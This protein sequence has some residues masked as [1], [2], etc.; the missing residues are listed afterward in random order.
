M[1]L[2][3][4]AIVRSPDNETDYIGIIDWIFVMD[5]LTVPFL[6]VGELFHTT[7]LQDQFMQR[8]LCESSM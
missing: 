3:T 5:W 1:M 2:H 7:C 6:E 4:K 8:S